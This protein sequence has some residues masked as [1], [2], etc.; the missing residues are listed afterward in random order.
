MLKWPAFC[1][2]TKSPGGGTFKEGHILREEDIPELLDVG[3]E[4]VFVREIDSRLVTIPSNH[5]CFPARI[6]TTGQRS[7]HRAPKRQV[8]P[9]RC[10]IGSDSFRRKVTE[11]GG[12]DVSNS[13][14]VMGGCDEEKWVSRK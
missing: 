4:D 6:V 12:Y 7:L 2:L 8:L 11:M 1:S 5:V 9:R 10:P 3:K 14:T 13:G